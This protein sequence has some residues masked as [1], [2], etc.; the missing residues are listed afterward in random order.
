LDNFLV[1]FYLILITLI[2]IFRALRPDTKKKPA[3]FKT[4]FYHV[5]YS[6]SMSDKNVEYGTILK[7]EKL[8]IKGKPDFVMESLLKKKVI[9]VEI[10]SGE[11]K[12]EP[13]PHKG[14][15]MQLACYFAMLEEE[16]NKK[17]PYGKIIYRDYMFIVY[18]TKRLRKELVSTIKT[19]RAMLD[20]KSVECES[21]YIK[22]RHCV[23]KL[24]VCEFC[25]K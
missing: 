15:L 10:K 19:M 18:N 3:S 21:E 9:P 13:L 14:D 20:G 8:D 6:D 24:T 16:Y 17:V 12:E 4:G 1:Y 22:C 2:I 7:S 11:I 25:E 5:I 23:C